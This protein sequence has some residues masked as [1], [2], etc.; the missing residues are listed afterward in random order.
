LYEE[1]RICLIPIGKIDVN[2]R[3]QI[4]GSVE[5]SFENLKAVLRRFN[6]VSSKT[7]ALQL[8]EQD[9]G[10]YDLALL[11]P[12]HGATAHLQ[13]AVAE[14]LKL[15]VVI[16]SLPW[17]FSFPTS[18]SAYGALK[19]KGYWAN[20]LH[21]PPDS[22]RLAE[23]V[24]CLARVSSALRK[25]SKTRVG[26]LGNLPNYMVASFYD[27]EALEKRFGIR[28]EQLSHVEFMEV[29]NFIQQDLK[30]NVKQSLP[31]DVS[32]QT[33]DYSLAKGFAV[34]KAIKEVLGRHHLDAVA[35]GCH[36]DLETELQINPCLGYIEDSYTIGCECD[37]LSL[38]S[39]LILKY[40]SGS[41]GWI[42]DIYSLEDNSLTLVH[43]AAPRSLARGGQVL[44]SGRT[45][46][47][48]G[49]RPPTL[50]ECRPKISNEDATLV[51]FIG[52]SADRLHLVFGKVLDCDIE[53]QVKVVLKLHGSPSEFVKYAMGNHYTFA[54]GDL[55]K[56]VRILC[57][58]LN[59]E[60]IET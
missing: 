18:A 43:C 32:V 40:L 12:L 44:I 39:A 50:A 54:L 34:H 57:E 1:P 19:E 59:I 41:S 52:K 25:L 47:E 16:W 56:E 26:I 5:K 51:R 55:R 10:N 9:G 38:I 49:D 7:E 35:I 4:L 37:V 21:G 20:L 31:K 29:L 6:V 27:I 36:P 45:Q 22:R 46:K 8:S 23:E 17:R 28:F 48:I 13:V 53:E 58:R 60:V 3:E 30:G 11:I 2:I 42:T 15:P 24:A 33:D 14:A